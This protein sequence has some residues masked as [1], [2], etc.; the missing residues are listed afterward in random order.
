MLY[1]ETEIELLAKMGG[2]TASLFLFHICTKKGNK[3]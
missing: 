2:S 3:L 1:P